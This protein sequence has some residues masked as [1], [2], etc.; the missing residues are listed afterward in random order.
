MGFLFSLDRPPTH[1]LTPSRTP[2]LTVSRTTRT[3]HTTHSTEHRA[4]RWL[5]KSLNATINALSGRLCWM[6]RARKGP[7]TLGRLRKSLNATKR[8]LWK[9]LL[10]AACAK[11]S[12]SS[13]GG[14]SGIYTPLNAVSGR[15]CWM[16][17][18]RKGPRALGRLRKSLNATKRSC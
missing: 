17:R 16:R 1:S 7:R 9:A 2:S 18:A 15:L 14:G 12:Q 11:R 8:S 4:S 10:D 5:R 6:R 13:A 3:T